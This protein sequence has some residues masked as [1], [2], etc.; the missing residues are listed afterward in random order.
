MFIVKVTRSIAFTTVLATC[1]SSAMAAAE[2]DQRSGKRRGPPQEAFEVCSD[3]TDGAACSFSGRRGDV[4]GS[5][6]VPPQSQ[7][8]LVCVPEGGPPEH[9]DATTL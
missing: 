6:I 3:Q 7:G 9:H 4:A 1:F 2:P 5:C 8:E